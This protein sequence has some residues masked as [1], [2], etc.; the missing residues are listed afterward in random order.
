MGRRRSLVQVQ[1]PRPRTLDSFGGFFV[2]DRVI[3]NM[4][5]SRKT[6]LISLSGK[7]VD[8]SFAVN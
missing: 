5:F 3:L 6:R 1:L 2:L 8:K 4:V 7:T